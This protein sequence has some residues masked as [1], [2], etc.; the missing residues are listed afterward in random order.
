MKYNTL[1]KI[2]TFG[3]SIWLGYIRRDLLT[4]GELL[5]L[6]EEDGLRGMT[7]NP[8]IF[9][10]AIAESNIYD[11][12]I[13][14]MATQNKDINT[15]NKNPKYS[16][17]KYI[18]ALIGANTVNTVP[19]KTIVAYR[20]HGI[21]RLNLERNIKKVKRVFINLPKLGIDI[22]KITQQLEDE[23]IS[24]F[25]EPFDKLMEALTKK[26]LT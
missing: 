16:D 5:Q 17:V 23:G 15:I 24:K 8:A 21:P 10:K 19:P 7:S 2:E 3:Q 1:K 22:N 18:E 6:I 4:S 25:N 20:D 13:R 26:S 9:Q 11:A 12:D 14:K